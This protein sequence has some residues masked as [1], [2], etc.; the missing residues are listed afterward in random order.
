MDWLDKIGKDLMHVCNGDVK[1]EGKVYRCYMDNGMVHASVS[2]GD[3]VRMLK[4]IRTAPK[5]ANVSMESYSDDMVITR[6]LSGSIEFLHRQGESPEVRIEQSKK[7]L[8]DIKFNA[9]N[10]D[11]KTSMYG[12]V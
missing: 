1:K 8:M 6:S 4:I 9:E 11:V 12:L 3:N 2:P 5:Y 7:K 10:P